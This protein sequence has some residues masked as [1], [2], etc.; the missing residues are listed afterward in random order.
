MTS[1]ETLAQEQAQ[2]RVWPG[3]SPDGEVNICDAVDMMRESYQAMKP[4]LATC[5]FLDYAG[6]CWCFHAEKGGPQLW[7]EEYALIWE[8][9]SAKFQAC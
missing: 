5:P 6:S 2:A 9:Q 8:S 7:I 3:I 4:L 1:F